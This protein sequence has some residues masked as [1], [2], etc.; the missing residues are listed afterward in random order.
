[1]NLV[2][3]VLELVTLL[4][5]IGI[6]LILFRP[7]RRMVVKDLK[8]MFLDRPITLW[9]LSL[10]LIFFVFIPISIPFSI[11]HIMIESND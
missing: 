5:V 2:Y 6:I 4:N 8:N 1:M 9:G 3:E 11:I 7:D 10:F